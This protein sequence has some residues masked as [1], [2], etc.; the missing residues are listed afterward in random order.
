MGAL[1]RQVER[2]PGDPSR[3]VS[4]EALEAKFR[5]CVSFAAELETIGDVA[6]IMRLL[7]PEPTE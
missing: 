2:V 5:D 6:E 4:R 1:S 7:T 3:S